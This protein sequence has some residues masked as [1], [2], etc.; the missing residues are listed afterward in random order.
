MLFL[1]GIWLISHSI[2]ES[3][4]KN[5]NLENNL[6]LWKV[7]KPE[8]YSYVYTSGCMWINRYKIELREQGPFITPLNN[9]PIVPVILIDGLFKQVRDANF[10]AHIVE[11][12]YHPYF[13]FPTV[14][15]TDWSRDI[16]DDECFI[17]ATEFKVLNS[18]ET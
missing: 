4:R 6:K 8:F 9:A 15:S 11:T 12:E 17:Q 13:G 1:V 5:E 14:M 7:N 3:K 10:S 16:I 2:V 18:N